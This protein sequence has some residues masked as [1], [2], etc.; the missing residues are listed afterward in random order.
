M[1]TPREGKRVQP[2]SQKAKIKLNEKCVNGNKALS[3]RRERDS[4]MQI[5]F[6][7]SAS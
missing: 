6:P 1:Y 2:A 4:D 3:I 5:S 7:L